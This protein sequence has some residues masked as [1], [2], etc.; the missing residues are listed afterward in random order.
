[1]QKNADNLNK[2]DKIMA[3][4]I[5]INQIISS[6]GLTGDAA[7]KKCAELEKLSVDEL[8]RILSGCTH[9]KENNTGS[10]CFLGGIETFKGEIF[11]TAPQ[12]TQKNAR[13]PHQPQKEYTYSQKRELDKFF[14][15]FL[16]R[17]TNAAYK[18]M[19]EFND[20]VGFIDVQNGINNFKY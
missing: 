15:D 11:P 2:E 1:M 19:E 14:A 7:E 5:T 12:K 9:I 13:Q 17:T 20:S 10:F 18:N 6:L 16:Y 3:D 8:N 4:P